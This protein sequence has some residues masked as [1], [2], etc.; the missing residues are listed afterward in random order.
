M[1]NFACN[2]IQKFTKMQKIARMEEAQVN[3]P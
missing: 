1:Q 2:I 3:L